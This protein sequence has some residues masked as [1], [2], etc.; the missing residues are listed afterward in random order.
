MQARHEFAHAVVSDVCLLHSCRQTQDRQTAPAFGEVL[1]AGLNLKGFSKLCPGA[2]IPDQ[3]SV[4]VIAQHSTPEQ[5]PVTLQRP[6]S[7]GNRRGDIQGGP[8]LHAAF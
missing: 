6:S 8:P 4:A 3:A 1:Q 2:L 5:T 7:P